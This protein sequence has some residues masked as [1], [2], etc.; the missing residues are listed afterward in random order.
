MEIQAAIKSVRARQDQRVEDMTAVRW[1]IID[2]D[3][4]AIAARWVPRRFAPGRV[5]RWTS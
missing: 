2:G 5:N 4:S 1:Q 3:W